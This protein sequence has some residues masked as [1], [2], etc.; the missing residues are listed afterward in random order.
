MARRFL[1]RLTSVDWA[2]Q[3]RAAWADLDT[4]DDELTRTI[5]K[6]HV[7]DLTVLID[8]ETLSALARCFKRE[9]GLAPASL[10]QLVVTG[11]LSHLGLDPEGKP[12]LYDQATLTVRSS[13]RYRH[14]PPSRARLGVDLSGLGRCRPPEPE[15]VPVPPRATATAAVP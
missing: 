11:Y 3:E 14:T 5:A 7:R 12:Y 6:S 8:G 2:H 1:T 13:T 4:E 9:R 15:P 10:E